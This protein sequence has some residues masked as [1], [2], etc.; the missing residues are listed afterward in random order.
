[1]EAETV[2]SGGRAAFPLEIS[3]VDGAV[4]KNF[5]YHVVFFALHDTSIEGY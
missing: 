2:R 1:M 5:D 4:A 3:P